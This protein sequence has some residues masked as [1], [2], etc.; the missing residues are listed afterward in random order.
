MPECE[1]CKFPSIAEQAKNVSLSL[2]NVMTQ[3]LKTGHVLA[4]QDEIESRITKCKA[5]EFLKDNRCSKCGCYIALK[6]GLKSEKCPLG[7]W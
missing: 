4:T 5:C 3:A 6:S 2:F 7:V 1:G